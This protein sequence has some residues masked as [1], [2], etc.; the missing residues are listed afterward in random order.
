MAVA[1]SN[2]VSNILAIENQDLSNPILY[3]IL[4]LQDDGSF[5]PI[6]NYDLLPDIA[7]AAGA[8]ISINL[9]NDGVYSIVISGSPNTVYYFLMDFSIKT[10]G[11]QIMQEILCNTCGQ[12]DMCGKQ[13]HYLKIEALIKYNVIKNSL[14]Y[15]WNQIVETQSIT[16]LI[17]ADSAK[18][19]MLSDL[20]SKLNL[21]CNNCQ[22]ND[23]CQNIYD[24]NNNPTGNCNCH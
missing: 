18:L 3:T 20:T 19:L 2:F 10:C 22:S 24:S 14:Y 9:V 4:S 17:A 11:K 12:V 13:A 8:T 6:I 1:I 15:I 16:D 21:V 7:L 23:I 5:V